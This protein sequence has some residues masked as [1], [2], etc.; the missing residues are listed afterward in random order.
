M[1]K[2]TLLAK[3][4]IDI[5][6]YRRVDSY[7]RRN[8]VGY[9]PKKSKTLNQTEVLEFLNQAPDEDYLME[10]VLLLVISLSNSSDL[11]VFT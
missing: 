5:G 11:I 2:S 7:L 10:K 3:D 1:L 4:N 8:S 9:L 6:K